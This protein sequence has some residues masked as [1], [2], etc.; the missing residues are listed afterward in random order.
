MKSEIFQS[1]NSFLKNNYGIGE[2][3]F[4]TLLLQHN[5]KERFGQ[6]IVLN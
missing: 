2:M 3:F 1:T 5:G 6:N 4:A